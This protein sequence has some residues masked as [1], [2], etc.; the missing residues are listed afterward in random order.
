[1]MQQKLN[2]SI[3]KRG[4]LQDQFGAPAG[5]AKKTR[6]SAG[7]GKKKFDT[8]K[9]MQGQGFSEEDSF[10]IV[11]LHKGR[12]IDYLGFNKDQVTRL[13]ELATEGFELQAAI[14][15]IKE[16]DGDADLWRA[17]D[18]GAAAKAAL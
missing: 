2:Y 14:T 11:E 8:F 10:Y 17:S 1:M 6:P 7:W 18:K 3:G 4:R 15:V 12:W 5:I 9:R 13:G 16:F